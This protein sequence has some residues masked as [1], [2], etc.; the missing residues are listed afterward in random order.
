MMKVDDFLKMV[1]KAV[2]LP[3]LYVMGGWGFPLNASNKERTQKNEYNR[4]EARKKKIFA[5]ADNVF[6]WDCVGLTKG[7]LWGW[8][9]DASKRNGGCDVQGSSRYLC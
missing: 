7:I 9:G 4:R 8:T 2:E 5:A 3:S 6:G 1:R